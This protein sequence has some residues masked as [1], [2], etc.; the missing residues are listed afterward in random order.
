MNDF[1]IADSAFESIDPETQGSKFWAPGPKNLK[2][3]Q[4]L[5]VIISIFY[6]RLKTKSSTRNPKIIVSR[7]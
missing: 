3:G 1:G 2:K 5:S 7:L 4:N 6:V